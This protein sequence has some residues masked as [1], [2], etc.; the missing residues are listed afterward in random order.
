MSV[1]GAA[2]QQNSTPSLF[3]GGQQS[4][5]AFG[6]GNQQQQQQQPSAFGQT[7]TQAQPAGGLFGASNTGNNAAGSGGGLFG[8][9]NA[10]GG[11]GTGAGLFGASTT[12]N[13][14]GGSGLFG[15]NNATAGSGTGTGL[16]GASNNNNA[17]TNAGG[18]LFGANAGNNAGGTGTGLFGSTNN[19]A[20]S[21]TGAGLFGSTNN[22]ANAGGAGLFGSTNAGNNA[23]GGLFG[24]NKSTAGTG[25]GLF[26]QSQPQQTSAFGGGS[27]FGQQQQKPGLF[28]A[29]AMSSAPSVQM[30]TPTGPPPFVKATKFN[31]LPDSLKKTFEDIEAHIQ[32][33]VQIGNELKQRKLGEEAAKGQDTIRSVHKDMA[34][35]VA[36][37]QADITSTRELRA[38]V[39]QTV[40]DTI[41]ATQ[42]IDGFR[43]P[44]QHGAHLKTRAGFPFEYFSRITD[45]MRERLQWYKAT[46]EQIERKL[47][48]SAQA[49]QFTPQIIVATLEAQNSS[50]LALAERVAGIDADLQRLKGVY[51]QLWR[52]QTGSTRDPFN[53]LDRGT[54]DEFG[55]D[56]LYRKA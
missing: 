20:G 45:E 2:S 35:V 11:A 16:F 47:T 30:G 51:T 23:G 39:D 27:A 29:S 25:T 15:S 37:L 22:N 10:A 17:N 8:Q 41:A 53:T 31:D 12:N 13:A 36:T 21:S 24:G 14:S 42:I 48:S 18:G 9:N 28:G 6:G 54:G 56:G 26:G 55:I 19:N 7:K 33:R 44:Q 46:L 52:Q 43:N 4:G 34:N 5:S 38:R 40:Q 49:V 50:S 3:G 32:G 1:F